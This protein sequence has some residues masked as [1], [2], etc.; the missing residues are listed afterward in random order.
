MEK[1]HL[2]QVIIALLAIVFVARLSAAPLQIIE[3]A[4]KEKKLVF[5]TVL[6]VPESLALVKSFQKKY[7]FI[8]PEF[9]RLS[10]E[11][12]RTKIL[13]EAR[14]G[15]H[16]FDV[17]SM[18]VVDTGLL[19]RAG[20]LAAYKASGRQAIPKGL[21]DD[22]GYWT[23]IYLRQFVL[24][25]NTNLVSQGEAPKDW[26]DLLEPRWKEKI[27]MD[28]EETEWYAALAN[29]WGKEKAQ[30]FMR[31]LAAQNPMLHRGHTLI[32]QLTIAGMFPLSIAYANRIEQ[33]KGQGAPIDWVD[34]SD[35]IVTSP[36]AISLSAHAPHPN[37][38]RLFIEYVLSREGQMLF[39]KAFRVSARR[40]IPPL[41][42]KLD[43]KRLPVFFVNPKIADHY[44]E[45]QKEYRE[46]WR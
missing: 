42:A 43:L 45:F 25:Y 4:K 29:Y 28:E 13:I 32:A 44:N 24:A 34:T 7:P 9:F 10:A 46:I 3:E 11:K 31:G 16:F 30:K 15:R 26:W 35:P 2:W 5:Y 19:L 39:H 6:T 23:A 40:D 37:V 38:G 18:N 20:L 27:G 14:A 41:S 21:K 1:H 36:S 22:D 17:A 12:M 8:Q 33:M